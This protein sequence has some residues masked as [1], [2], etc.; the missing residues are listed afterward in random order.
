MENY[1]II[2]KMVGNIRELEINYSMNSEEGKI[3]VILRKRRR[4]R[5]SVK[6]GTRDIRGK[7]RPCGHVT[8]VL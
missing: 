1:D 3:I 4:W 5:K 6:L 7:M 2:E 8:S